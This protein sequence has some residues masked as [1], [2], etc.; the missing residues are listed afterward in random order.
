MFWSRTYCANCT[1]YHRNHG[2]NMVNFIFGLLC[3]F[4]GKMQYF[5]HSR[6]QSVLSDIGFARVMVEQC[7]KA[8]LA[9]IVHIGKVQ[10]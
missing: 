9:L 10:L 4:L 3:A 5:Q 8:L 7:R 6:F 2:P 1:L